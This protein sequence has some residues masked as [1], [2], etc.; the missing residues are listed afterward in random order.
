MS[1]VATCLVDSPAC[2]GSLLLL[3]LLNNQAHMGRAVSEKRVKAVMLD[4]GLRNA[5]GGSSGSGRDRRGSAD[6][7]GKSGA[8]GGGAGPRAAPGSAD[9]EQRRYPK[10]K[11]NSAAALHVVGPDYMQVYI[12]ILYSRYM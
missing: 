1:G 4:A 10:T 2:P 7:G 8:T 11:Q 12:C 3:L 5:A 6:G 9:D